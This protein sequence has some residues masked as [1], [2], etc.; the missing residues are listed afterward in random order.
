MR[1]AS[2]CGLGQTA[3]TAVAVRHDQPRS[4]RA[5]TVIGLDAVK[6]IV[7][8]TV[9]GQEVRVTEGSTILDALPPAR[10]RDADAL[11]RRHAH[12]GERLPRLRRRGRRLARARAG[13]LAQGRAGNGRAHRLAARADEPPA[14]ARAAR[15]RRS[16]SPPLPTRCATSRS[17]RREPERFGATLDR[18]AGGEGRQRALRARLLEVHPLLQVRRGLRRR[19]PEH[20]RDRRRRTRLRAR[21]SPPSSTS[22]CRSRRA[23]TAATASRYARRAR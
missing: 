8:L 1:D 17:T 7:E 2:I 21:T 15:A 12:A 14:R 10:D 4:A 6:R 5:M 16:T 9:D 11:L 19:P 22:S 13:L 23:S 18:R 3:A 20:V